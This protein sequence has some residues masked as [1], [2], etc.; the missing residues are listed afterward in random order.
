MM[1]PGNNVIAYQTSTESKSRSVQVYE[2]KMKQ[3][4]K[5]IEVFWF[6]AGHGS[7]DV[8]KQIDHQE[9][10]LRFAYQVL[11]QQSR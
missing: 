9:R 7:L 1:R 3:L 4:G 8:E 11:N 5:P 2:E 6:D 10:M